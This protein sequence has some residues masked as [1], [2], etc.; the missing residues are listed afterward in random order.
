MSLIVLCCPSPV[1]FVAAIPICKIAI[2]TLT[3]IRNSETS[4]GSKV[5]AQLPATTVTK[6]QS[7]RVI[8]FGSLTV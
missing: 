2:C 7:K 8:I 5:T 1:E 6:E 3:V 4:Q